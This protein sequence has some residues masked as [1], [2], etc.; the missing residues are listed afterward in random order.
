[1]ELCS[2]AEAAALEVVRR[3][4]EPASTTVQVLLRK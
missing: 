4:F 2:R 1:M 3:Y